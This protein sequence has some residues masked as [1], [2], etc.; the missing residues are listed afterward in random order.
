MGL[1]LGEILLNLCIPL[2]LG[3]FATTLG[4]LGRWLGLNRDKIICID[5]VHI[6]IDPNYAYTPGLKPIAVG[7]HSDQ[8]S[9]R[10]IR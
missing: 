8:G 1:I 9:F 7:A 5:L 3:E 2:S 4:F 6:L 10:A